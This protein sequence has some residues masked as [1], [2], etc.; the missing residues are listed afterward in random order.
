[1]L[2]GSILQEVELVPQSKSCNFKLF[3]IVA[4]GPR[5]ETGRSVNGFDQAA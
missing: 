2:D 1:M 5:S 4:Y 3:A